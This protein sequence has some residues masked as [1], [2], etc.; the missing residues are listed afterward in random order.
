M[1]LKQTLRILTFSMVTM[2]FVNQ[3][4][5]AFPIKTENAQTEVVISSDATV[6]TVIPAKNADTNAGSKTKLAALLLCLFLGVFGIHRFYLGYPILGIVYL[7][8]G[9]GGGLFVLI[10]LILLLIGGLGPKNGQFV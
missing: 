5:A 10:D 7:L 8:T 3:V 6:D 4:N 2:L 1:T 9:G